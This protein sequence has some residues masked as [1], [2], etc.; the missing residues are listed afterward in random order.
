MHGTSVESLRAARTGG[1]PRGRRPRPAVIAAAVAVL[2]AV[3]VAG[4]SGHASTSAPG[5]A[6]SSPAA[7]SPA[8]SGA[9][10]SS[11]AAA[12]PLAWSAARAPLPA[13]ATGV[14][15]QFVQLHDVSCTSVGNCVA[16]GGDRASG[17]GG[18][19]FQ[20]LVETLS[21]GTWTPTTLPDVSSKM[22]FAVLDAVSCPARGSCVAVGY[23]SP[24][25]EAFTPVIETLS[26]GRWAPVK[27]SLPADANTTAPAILTGVECP[28]V[29]PCVATGWYN[30]EGGPHNA[31]VDTLANGTWTAASVPLPGD[32]APE[33][34]SS[35]ISTYLAAVAC[36]QVGS[37]IATGQYRDGSGQPEPFIDTLSGGS[38]TAAR[39]TLPA[40]ATAAGQTATLSAVTC[41]AP[42]ACIA[43]GNYMA[44][45]Q[46]RY[47]IETQSGGTWTAAGLPLPADAA[48]D[49]KWS[50]YMSTVIGAL[51]CQAAG[52]CVAT[53]SY[54]DNAN[55]ILPVIE[56]LSAGTWTAT[57]AP[58]PSDAALGAGQD[59]NAAFLQ[60]VTCPAVGHCLTVG[61]YPAADGTT[62]GM[63]ETAVP[64]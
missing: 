38:W 43:A 2:A 46:P 6:A 62:E 48:A 34:S 41:P 20:G 63:I 54:M 17:A 7:S 56:T 45:G 21:D 14:S 31:Y 36:P 49:Q 57:Q 29:G 50:Q 52:V 12:V 37:C 5:G 19:V 47:L 59:N 32:A 40:D 24:G 58:L 26:G 55:E 39:A 30:T 8:A 15:G 33:E 9:V 61:S 27:P 42:G 53:A 10:H 25:P 35:S 22:G 1:R 16:V 51:A 3:G 28:A 64:R 44:G 60:L 18:E 23:V 4:C 11:A 13:D